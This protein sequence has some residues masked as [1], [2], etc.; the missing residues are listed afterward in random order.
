VPADTIQYRLVV[1]DDGSATIE[2]VSGKLSSLGD[3]AR[4]TSSRMEGFG[5]STQAAT[6]A[7]HRLYA[8]AGAAVA[9]IG[10]YGLAKSFIEA[11]DAD[12]RLTR[13]LNYAL[14]PL[15]RYS[16]E[17]ERLN[18]WL[19]ELSVKELRG[20]KSDDLAKAAVDLANFGISVRENITALGE[21]AMQMGRPLGEIVNIVMMAS[22]GAYRGLRRLGI[23][24]REVLEEAGY[25]TQEEMI[26][27]EEGLERG[28]Q[29]VLNIIKS[30]F[31]GASQ[32]AQ[33]EWS[34]MVTALG[35][36][37]DNFKEKVMQAGVFDWLKEKLQRLV[38]YLEKAM[39]TGKLDEWAKSVGEAVTRVLD[40]VWSFGEKVSAYIDKLL[41]SKDPLKALWNDIKEEAAKVFDSIIE[42]VTK[43]TDEWLKAGQAIGRGLID[44]I[45]S[46]VR[47]EMD[48]ITQW[49][50]HVLSKPLSIFEG[51]P[52]EWVISIFGEGSRRLPISEKIE[53]IRA[54]MAGL[55][56]IALQQVIQFGA[57]GGVSLDALILS[58]KNQISALREEWAQWQQATFGWWAGSFIPTAGP[59]YQEALGQRLY[60]DRI[61][62]LQEQ[63][64]GLELAAQ[65]QL[66]GSA[67]AG[68][69]AAGGA[70]VSI[71]FG[72]TSI[73]IGGVP[74]GK[75]SDI[76][77]LA[78]D[79]ER[80]LAARIAS[81]RSRILEALEGAL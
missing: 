18:D 44:G 60:G 42:S 72:P 2:R 64:Q 19:D 1:K 12:E 68:R 80:E 59:T 81:R 62:Q 45:W 39:M 69:A 54:K 24:M 38:D 20:I 57:P 4:K 29:A 16:K 52:F 66:A 26:A 14:D 28:T 13:Q 35:N 51:G 11:A 58:V 27:T 17:G 61:S 67:G 41:N 75:T 10:T 8:A 46:V 25:A 47:E 7:L 43:K 15:N 65:I 56:N 32:A 79:L 49:I 76:A 74:S 40:S 5:S 30:R 73:N 23:Q 70:A 55:S 50:N 37:W 22:E 36:Y 6:S 48:W 31:S 71:S 21:A 63:L 53:E 3:E 33:G 9:A 77:Y 34:V 78:D